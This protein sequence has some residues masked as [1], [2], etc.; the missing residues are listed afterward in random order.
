MLIRELWACSELLQPLQNVHRYF[1][2]HTSDTCHRSR[3][4][5]EGLVARERMDMDEGMR[6]RWSLST[7]VFRN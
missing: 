5:E 3:I 7:H 6:D 1:G 4:E 2:L